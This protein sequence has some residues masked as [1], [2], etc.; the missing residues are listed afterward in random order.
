MKLLFNSLLCLGKLIPYSWPKRIWE[1]SL[2]IMMRLKK[3]ARIIWLNVYARSCK[4]SCIIWV[5]STLHA[6]QMS[7]HI[8][9][10]K[11]G[12]DHRWH[13][14]WQMKE[15]GNIIVA[16]NALCWINYSLPNVT[17]IVAVGYIHS[18]PKVNKITANLCG[19]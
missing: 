1:C 8:T 2:E 18:I 15:G 17:Y 3:V 16:Y 4:R 10:V 13:L 6:A 14:K 11:T 19:N 5:V 12:V 9:V 7:L